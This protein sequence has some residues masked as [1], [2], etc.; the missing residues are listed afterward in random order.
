MKI[1]N[2]FLMKID[3]EAFL[4]LYER[5]TLNLDDLTFLDFRKFL[6]KKYYT[7]EEE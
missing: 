3:V 2:D 4:L 1:D 7:E 5:Q 6:Y